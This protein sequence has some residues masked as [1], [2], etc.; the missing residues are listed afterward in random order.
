MK[1]KPFIT[2]LVNI[3]SIARLCLN[4]SFNFDYHSIFLRSVDFSFSLEAISTLEDCH[5]IYASVR[6]YFIKW[7]TF[8]LSVITNDSQLEIFDLKK[9]MHH[10]CDLL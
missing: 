8:S 7:R 9:I 2:K 5:L 6:N 3:K 4:I 10:D 1:Q